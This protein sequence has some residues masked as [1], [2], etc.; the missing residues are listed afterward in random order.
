[1]GNASL[2]RQHVLSRMPDAVRGVFPGGDGVFVG[3]CDGP[4]DRYPSLVYYCEF[5]CFQPLAP[6]ADCSSLIVVW[7]AEDMLRPIPE[8]VASW[9]GEVDW[10]RH[11]VDGVY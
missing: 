6:E 11:A 9:I 1:M 2:I 8:F 7:F 5:T 10:E 4:A 3:P